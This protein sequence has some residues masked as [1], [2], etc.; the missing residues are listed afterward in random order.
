MRK[1]PLK[2]YSVS[3]WHRSSC[4]YFKGK[5]LFSVIDFCLAISYLIDVVLMFWLLLNWLLSAP[6]EICNVDVSSWS[7]VTHSR[8]PRRLKSRRHE[9]YRETKSAQ[10]TTNTH[11]DDI[12]RLEYPIGYK[13]LFR[14]LSP[15]CSLHPW[16]VVGEGLRE[17]DPGNQ[18]R[19]SGDNAPTILCNSNVRTHLLT[20][21]S[22]IFIW[23]QL[24]LNRFSFS[25]RSFISLWQ[26]YIEN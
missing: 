6:Q 16:T 1:G 18:T 4:F 26:I 19:Q 2:R 9:V 10:G 20:H 13:P 15:G 7:F 14:K 11:C 12:V 3:T 23:L 25:V 24:S 17:P 5:F 22:V 21:Q 8:E